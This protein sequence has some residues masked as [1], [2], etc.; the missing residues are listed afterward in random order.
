MTDKLQRPVDARRRAEVARVHAGRNDH[1]VI[2]L[3]DAGL[4]D[5]LFELRR[6]RHHERHA[7][8]GDPPAGLVVVAVDRAGDV[9]GRVGLSPAAVDRRAD[10]EH[11]H[12][13]I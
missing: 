7:V 3:V 2:V 5:Q 8:A 9:A 13:R 1:D 12:R 11:D 6:G 10:V 4:A